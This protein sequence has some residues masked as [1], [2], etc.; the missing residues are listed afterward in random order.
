[1]RT[2]DPA[3]ERR[4]PTSLSNIFN[5]VEYRRGPG[6]SDTESLNG[7]PLFRCS[8]FMSTSAGFYLSS[9]KGRLRLFLQLLTVEVGIR[10]V[11]TS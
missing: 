5:D 10:G 8:F 6:L 4:G 2:R 1:M 7:F 9:K 3:V 11:F